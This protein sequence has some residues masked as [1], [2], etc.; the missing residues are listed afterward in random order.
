[1]AEKL[2]HLNSD[3]LRWVTNYAGHFSSTSIV[4]P[5]GTTYLFNA[6]LAQSSDIDSDGDGI[7]NLYDP[8]PFPEPPTNA[9]VVNITITMTNKPGLASLLTWQTIA[10]A[11]NYAVFYKTNFTMTNWLSLTNIYTPALATS[12]PVTVMISDPVTNSMRAYRVR[13]DIQ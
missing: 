7:A 12:P 4:F 1:M 9:N 5:D 3:H 6:A 13:A 10:N 11:T 8:T 2:N